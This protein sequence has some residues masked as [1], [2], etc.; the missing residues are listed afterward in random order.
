MSKWKVYISSTFIDLK[1]FRAE[2]INLFQN[3]LKNSFELNEIMERMFDDGTHTP[4]RDDC[5]DAVEKCDI[6]II[7]LGNR[8]G[9]FPPNEDRTYTEIELDTAVSND[10]QIFCLRLAEF[11]EDKID[12]KSKHNELLSKFKG[13]PNHK[14]NDSL[15]LKNV[16]FECLLPFT[17]QSPVNIKNPYKGLASF[18]VN[19]GDYFFGRDA[20]LD[21]CIKNILIS[22]N[23]FFL[24]VIGNSGTGKS[25]FVKAGLLHRLKNNEEYRFNERLQ[26]IVNPGNEPYTNLSY[27]LKLLG[28]SVTDLLVPNKETSDLIIYFDQFEEVVT[29]CHSPEAQSEV[30]KLFEFFDALA[31]SDYKGGRILVICSFRSDYLSQLVNYN[32][33]KSCQY[34]FPISSLDY[35]VHADNWEQS[36]SEIICKPALKNGV[37]IEKELVDQLLIQIKEVDGSLPILQFTLKHIWNK[38]TIED[39]LISSAEYNKLS[40]GKGISGIIETHAENVIKRITKNGH[41]KERET[42][43]KTIFVNLVEVNENKNDIKRTVDKDELFSILKNHNEQLVNQVFEDLVSEKSRLIN[44][45]KNKEETISV[46]IIHEELIRKWVRLIDWINER[47]QALETKKRILLDV[48]AHSKNDADHYNRGQVKRV[49]SWSLENPDLV[50]EEINTFLKVSSKKNT[51]RLLKNTGISALLFAFLI[52]VILI[53][54]QTS[55]QKQ[56]FLNDILKPNKNV[57]NEVQSSGG[58]D[59]LDELVIDE[60]NFDIFNNNLKHFGNLQTIEIDDVNYIEDLSIF[61]TLKNSNLVN[62]VKIWDN[63]NLINLNGIENL[64]NLGS[65]VIWGNENLVNVNGIENLKNLTSLEID[66]FQNFENLIGIQHL[67]NLTSLYINYDENLENLDGIENLKN[68]TSLEI[69]ENENLENLVGIENLKNLTSLVISDNEKLENLDGIENLKNLTSL[70]ISD[71]EKLENLDGIEN[72]KKLTYLDID[73]SVNLEN[74]IGV[75]HLKNLTYFNI[76][77]YENLEDLNGIQH[78]KNLTSLK[79]SD[80]ENLENIDGI[81]NLKN[82]TSLEIS[83]STK[84]NDLKGI[85]HFKNLT[86]LIIWSNK[87]LKNLNGIQHL[88]NLTSLEINRDSTIKNLKGIENLKNLD[89][90]VI[91]N[92]ANLVNLN[93]I[94]HLNNLTTLEIG[95]N[96]KLND[97]KGIEALKN[98]TSLKIVID[99]TIKNLKGIENLKNL[100]SLVIL[101][102]ANLVNLNGIQHLKD[103]TSLEISHNTKLNDLKGIEA[104]SELFILKIGGGNTD[105]LDLNVI[106]QIS[107]LKELVLENEHYINIDELQKNHPGLKIKFE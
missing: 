37:V 103:L 84:L 34:I 105:L 27:Q 100:T 25:S 19:D 52:T 23:N 107:S 68:L 36:M 3:Q 44:I 86:S 26:C 32:F 5:V 43:L 16:L 76:C 90:L 78:L 104:L 79:I 66:D 30:F 51:S 89:S 94:Q 35:K 33:I 4:F 49:T 74:L 6:Y 38:E 50:N 48:S 82:L 57:Y 88:K 95:N 59:L 7:I 93:G 64:K 77:S 8:T 71:N 22:E 1:D 61:N 101:N 91:L 10:K 70:V 41:D 31:D 40:E 97:L 85:E 13:R 14:F 98:L 39:R 102:N 83:F 21:S 55:L 92:N 46:G 28:L 24:S 96:T 47:R 56:Y 69:S 2:L 12:N 106:K 72:L 81:G 67:T 62:S 53:W 17:T 60:F 45:S 54:R 11:D 58:I 29:Q 20:E 15:T 99:S 87:N 73:S 9:S 75:Q 80:I 63:E 42:I 65:L 18:S